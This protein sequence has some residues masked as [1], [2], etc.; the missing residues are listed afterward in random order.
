MELRQ[1]RYFCAVAETASFS[2]AA[3]KTHV[4]QPSLSQ[5]IQK[6]E[7]EL[8]VRLFDRLGRSVRL[9]EPGRAFLPRARNI[10]HEVEEASSNI[11]ETAT[12]IGGSVSLGVIPTVAPYF[13]PRR[14]AVFSKK[15]PNVRVS[16]VEEITALLLEALRSGGV[17][18]AMLA[19]PLPARS[20]EFLSFPVLTEK[21]FAVLPKRHALA[22]RPQVSL[23]DLRD[24]PFLLLRD[25]H[26]FRDTALD[27]CKQAR[28]HPKVVF[29]S[30]QFSSILSM[31]AAGMG[32]SIVPKMA[33]DT[34]LSDCRFVPLNDEQ[35][36]RTIGAVVL[37]GRLLTRA[38]NAFLEQ[39]KSENRKNVAA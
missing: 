32:I 14:L 30:G 12:V 37:R 20:H 28:M 7:Q 36:R 23:D 39:L 11:Q 4:S 26:C 6:L 13:L 2:R 35:A 33:V 22:R 25:G 21:L 18:V 8:G 31:V 29:E 1:L 5:Q 38:Q 19:L 10:L 24:E 16:V 3:N 9:T 15:Y 27:V 34:H 17:D